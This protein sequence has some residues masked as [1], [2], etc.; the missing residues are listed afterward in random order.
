MSG[1]LLSF[2][3]WLGGADQVKVLEMF[4]RNWETKTYNINANLFNDNYV[5][6]ADYESLLLDTVTYDRASGEPN[7][8]DT[9]VIGKFGNL[10][11][12]EVIECSGVS[13]TTVTTPADLA[14][15]SNNG[16]LNVSGISTVDLTI[17]ANR[18]TGPIFPDSRQNVVATVL[19]FQ[20]SNPRDSFLHRWVI[21][22]RWEPGV[23]I[24][25][26][27]SD[28]SYVALTQPGP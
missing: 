9:L 5:L 16:G 3:Q 25:D 8:T 19:S 26:P 28:P 1:R 11:R 27:D 17:P 15:S 23:D 21:L 4:P 2:S 13:T 20:W 14:W 10:S 22:E 12:S 6:S 7:F 24:G 18:Y